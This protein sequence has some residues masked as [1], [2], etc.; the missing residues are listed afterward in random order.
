[1]KQV[2]AMLLALVVL[3]GSVS[4]S[5]GYSK[6]VT[7]RE[8][9]NAIVFKDQYL[10]SPHAWII[11]KAIDLL[12]HDG[13][14]QEADEAQR[15]LLP[16]LEGVTY[17]D[18][19]GDA[20]LAGGSVLDYYIPDSPDTHNGFGCAGFGGFFAY[21]N[22]TDSFKPPFY[23]YENAAELAQFRYDYALR[24][25]RG[26]WGD[27]PRDMMAGWVVDRSIFSGGGQ[28]DPQNGRWAAGTAQIDGESRFGGGH[29][30]AY[31]LQDMFDH[32]TR[33]QPVFPEQTEDELSS[34]HI[35]TKEVFDHKSEW[36]DDHY[37]D[38][39]DIEAYMGY[40][41]HGTAWYASWTLDAG[42]TCSD[43]D[44]DCASPMVVRLPVN[45]RAHA[46]FQI[47]WALHLLEDV[48]TPVHTINGSFATFEVHNDVE[49][50]ADEVLATPGVVYNGV[51]VKD[52]L[53]A[54]TLS[55][56][57]NLYSL[58][59]PSCGSKAVDPAQSFK[60]RW[61]A[62]TL[63]KQSGEGVA[64]AYVRNSAETSHQFI[65]Y[66]ECI[67][68]ED[69]KGWDSVGFFTASGL[70]AGVKS[71]AGLIHQFMSESGMA[72]TLPPSISLSANS[73]SPT[74]HN[75]L[76]FSGA[77]HDLGS[78]IKSVEYSL[79]DGLTWQAAN[80]A[81]GAFDNLTENYSFTTP[82][83]PDGTYAIRVR[84]SDV[85]NN[86]TPIPGQPRVV[87][88]V[89][90]TPPAIA[91]TEPRP[92]QYPHSAILTL[93]YS[94]TDQLSGVG[95]IMPTLDGATTLAGHGL[96]NSQAIKLITEL[97]LGDHTFLVTASDNAGNNASR[98]VTFAVVVTP[99]SIK[100][101]VSQFLA[102]GMIKNG[103]QANSLNAK[104]NAAADA[105]ARGDCRAAANNYAAFINELQAQSGKGVDA[106]AAKIMIADAQYLIAHCP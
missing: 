35:P 56:F 29:T 49:T 62:D 95:T 34:I 14:R 33:S 44:D 82:A 59:P 104:L 50:R 100:D 3:I 103:G 60:P 8:A 5:Y 101:D 39:D 67:N 48:T 64:H 45:S 81:D 87:I 23:G 89:D 94:V 47:G 42:G 80:A 16:M 84:A 71:A 69:D 57:R 85:S 32:Y 66:I 63:A 98:S 17:N 6:P 9:G 58:Q 88:V 36:L 10:Y 25:A 70:D 15:N 52:A 53:P 18:I 79:N 7:Y 40:D 77:A 41:G 76:S 102:L 75:V 83:L 74:N 90:T 96:D 61:Y 28:E 46:F 1:M 19:W 30:P 99:A 92:I 65:P 22:C 93:N 68:T 26:H 31:V 97:T 24:I 51:A 55:D 13:Y 4:T 2:T 12:R 11:V 72:D 27:D 43:G 37:N 20:D 21:K 73:P 86:M 38:A 54:L 105:R 106:N 91:I 78:N